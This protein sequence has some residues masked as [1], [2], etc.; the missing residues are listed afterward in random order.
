MM[1]VKSKPDE[2]AVAELSTLSSAVVP[3]PPPD[4]ADQMNQRVEQTAAA[5]KE[6]VAQVSAG[7]E[8]AQTKVKEGVEKAMKTAEEFVA[9]GQG[10]LEAFVKSGQI[11]AQ[12]IQ[13]LGKQAAAA[14]QSS[15]E[16]TVS[17]AKALAGAKTLREAIELQASYARSSL[18]KT[19]TES[20]K[21]TETSIK[22]TEQALAPITARVNLAVEK[23]A[24]PF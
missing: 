8:T 10:N 20:G 4:A 22:L 17:T 16:Q 3:T 18:E 15:F 6:T 11:W 1:A 14:A 12:G 7:F 9:F 2:V 23:F 24:K 5:F 13:D 21:L 19:L